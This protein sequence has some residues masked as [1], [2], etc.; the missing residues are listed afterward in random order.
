VSRAAQ[1]LLLLLLLLL[2]VVLVLDCQCIKLLA[3][4]RQPCCQCFQLGHLGSVNTGHKYT[5]MSQY[6]TVSH[7]KQHFTAHVASHQRQPCC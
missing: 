4:Q 2:E 6:T 7:G 5:R 1:L 3:Q